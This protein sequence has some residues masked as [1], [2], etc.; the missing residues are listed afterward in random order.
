MQPR[1]THI[2]H[3]QRRAGILLH[4]T[5][6]PG[7]FP[8]GLI[9]H[10]AYRFVDF[11]TRAGMSVWQMLPLGP[12]HSDGSP[13]HAL[14]AHACD[15]TL[16][17]LDWLVDRGLLGKPPA[18][19]RTT[20]HH[21]CLR[22]AWSVF[23]A[24]AQAAL[25]DEYRSFLRQQS[26]WLT[27]YALFMAI[28]EQQDNRQWMQ[29]PAH[30]R[31]RDERALERFREQYAELI[32]FHCFTQFIFFRQWLEL[33]SYANE[34]NILL[35]GDLPIYVALDSVD[36]WASRD[37]FML[38]ENGQPEYVAGVPPDY[39]SKTG[40]RWGNPQF[41]W[42][43]MQDSNFSWWQQRIRT[44]LGLFD[45]IRIDHFRGFQAYWEISA[46]QE[47][48]MNGRWVEAPGHALLEKLHDVFGKL[49]LVA[50]DLGVITGEVTALREEFSLPGMKVLQFAFDGD[51]G[52]SYLPHNH[53]FN[54]VVYTGTHDNDTTVSW[55]AQLGRAQREYL[56][57]YLD[58][59]GDAEMPW[60]L[61]RAALASPACLAMFPFQDLLGLGEG[62][63]MNI[64]GT[65]EG[66]WQWRFDWSQLPVQLDARCREL[67][68]LYGRSV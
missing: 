56:E 47:T 44:Q 30:L 58:I 52:N 43:A 64:P 65:A 61:L 37:L 15:T 66:N 33:K 7:P 14:S 45:V 18:D 40:Q 35:F 31:N 11:M 59:R 3:R 21:Q 68:G 38:D 51:P 42:P 4:P 16:I 23:H 22:E 13:Y 12:V 46:A 53:E 54:S 6:L 49:P 41:N 34:R 28:R 63:R 10:D 39:F 5:S 20:A 57:R 36:V 27:D 60:P 1:D 67:V 48:A 17:S 9:C 26:D 55:Y 19:Y 25:Q 29:W 2:L 62:H 24:G 32:D 50:E 8:H